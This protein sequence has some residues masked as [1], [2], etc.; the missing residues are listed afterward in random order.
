MRSSSQKT[1]E[2]RTEGGAAVGACHGGIVGAC[3]LLAAAYHLGK[4]SA[5]TVVSFVH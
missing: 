1:A 4:G 5:E 2:A 3:A